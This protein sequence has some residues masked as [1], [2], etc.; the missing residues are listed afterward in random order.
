M[1]E[2]LSLLNFDARTKEGITN[3]T[4]WLAMLVYFL[5]LN[6][7]VVPVDVSGEKPNYI[8]YLFVLFVPT[9]VRLIFFSGDSISFRNNS[10]ANFFQ[11]QFPHK[12]IETK[13]GIDKPLAQY[14]WFKALDKKSKEGAAR[15]TFEYGYTCRLV[16]YLRRLILGF[17]SFQL[18][19]CWARPV[20]S[21]GGNAGAGMAF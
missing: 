5:F 14:L 1:K 21:T 17:A 16:Y 3:I 13:F 8:F 6:F 18:R 19:S 20:P 15:K 4:V 9:A 2:L 12:Y 7:F 10:E 11:R